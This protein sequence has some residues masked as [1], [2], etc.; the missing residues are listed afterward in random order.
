MVSKCNGDISYGIV[1]NFIVVSGCISIDLAGN[2]EKY[3]NLINECDSCD[4]APRSGVCGGR[5]REKEL[6]CHE[7]PVKLYLGLGV[8]Q[9][10]SVKYHSSYHVFFFF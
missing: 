4:R 3:I 6:K 5:R 7:D 8:V 9:F 1:D 10:D 2:G